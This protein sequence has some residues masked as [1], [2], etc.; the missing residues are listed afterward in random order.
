MVAVYGGPGA[1]CVVDAWRLT[2]DRSAHACAGGGVVTLKLDNRGTANRGR[3]FERAIRSN[4]AVLGDVEVADQVAGVRFLVEKRIVDPKRVAIVGWSYGG[5]V[6]AAAL[7]RAPETFAC[8]VAARPSRRGS[9]TT[10]TIP[11]GTWARPARRGRVAVP[12]VRSAHL[13][14]RAHAAGSPRVVRVSQTGK[15][16]ALAHGASDENVHLSHTARLADALAALDAAA[17]RRGSTETE[18]E[19]E[20]DDR[21]RDGTRARS[22]EGVSSSFDVAVF[23]RERH[24]PRGRVARREFE[25]RVDAFLADAFE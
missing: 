9:P 12:A 22:R 1:Q 14:A 21:R 8:A 19:T 11:S 17:A 5:F 7:L 23:A 4:G 24:V 10:R 3:A 15:K 2:A 20:E 25:E 13:R 6:A 18:T 16:N